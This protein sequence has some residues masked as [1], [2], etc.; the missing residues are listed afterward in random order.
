MKIL[1]YFLKSICSSAYNKIRNVEI[2]KML[3]YINRFNIK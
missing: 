1:E 2:Y 3:K